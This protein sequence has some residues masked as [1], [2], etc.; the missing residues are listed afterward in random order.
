[1]QPGCGNG[2]RS[3]RASGIAFVVC[4][5]VAAALYG[6]GA[7]S[8][9]VSIAAYYAHH[10]GRQIAGFA[11]LLAGC[12]CLLVYVTTATASAIGRA[13]GL[14]ATVLLAV[15]NGLWAATAFTVELEP[16]YVPSASSH[17]LLEDA[18]WIVIVSGA[19]LAIP[20]V[21]VVSWERGSAWLRVLGAA[22]VLR[23]QPPTGTCRSPS[24]SPGSSRK[25]SAEPELH[26]QAAAGA[27]RR[28]GA[29]AL[30]AL[31]GDRLLARARRSHAVT[32]FATRIGDGGATRWPW[33]SV[34]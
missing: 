27:F 2:T 18:A 33:D 9:R 7:G 34:P 29:L 20:F 4:F 15:G 23:S 26:G 32:S 21:A 6:N 3:A 12:A 16:G 13:S 25:A 30:G 19:A 17:L 31:D 22:T 10:G 8:T 5:A 1:L 24:S 14:A 28:S 11:V